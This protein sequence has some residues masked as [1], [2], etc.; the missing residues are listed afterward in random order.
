MI[1]GEGGTDDE[2][3]RVS[4]GSRAGVNT[5]FEVLAKHKIGCVQMP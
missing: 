2:E 1:N 5:T 4:C 3:F